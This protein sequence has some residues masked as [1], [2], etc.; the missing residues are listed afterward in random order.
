[1]GILRL[2]VPLRLAQRCRERISF[3]GDRERKARIY[4]T[5]RNALNLGVND[6]RLDVL[7]EMLPEQVDYQQEKY[8]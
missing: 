4:S 6:E 1:M 5:T 8:S 3:L 2:I 7:V